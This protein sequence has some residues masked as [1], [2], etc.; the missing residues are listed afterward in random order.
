MEDDR[1]TLKMLTGKPT[2]KKPLGT[3]R[4]RC[5]DNIRMYLKQI[6][7]IRGIGMIQLGIG[8]IGEPL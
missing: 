4:L 3:P 5:E 6:V 1:R 8:I 7:V 2:G